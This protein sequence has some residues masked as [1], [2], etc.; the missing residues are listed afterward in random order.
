MSAIAARVIR[1]L[2]VDNEVEL[3]NAVCDALRE[4]GLNVT[5]FVDP[6]AA[7]KAIEPDKFDLILSDLMM[8][9]LDG[10]QLLKQSLQID[11]NLIGIIMT[12]AGS[13]H[14]AVEAMRAG[15]YDFVLKPFRL[16][17]ILPTLDRAM[18]IRQMRTDNERLKQ[19][20]TRLEAE[21]VR[22][23]EEANAQ[24]QRLASTDPLT[25]LTNRRTFDEM[26]THEAVRASRG[27]GPLSLILLDVDHFKSFNDTFG[28]P[29]GDD[30][31][32]QIASAMSGCC[33]TT[34]VPARIGGE[35]FAV[36]LP[37]TGT[38]GA[39]VLAE[40]IRQAIEAGPW[41]LRPVTASF[42]IATLGPTGPQSLI[43]AADRALYQAKHTGRNRIV[44]ANVNG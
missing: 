34:D 27:M 31:L 43:E 22:L 2:V 36:L 21:R 14:T 41:P 23:L 20:V 4:Q 3:L 29:A 28:H 18:G 42:G 38:E 11:P 13:I 40:R 8:P 26:L 7:L 44:S 30:V 17:Q 16:N 25:A 6:V 5:G 19:E 15:A 24:L 1:L 10:I 37:G 33:R 9:E 12:G 32:R 35:E 39:E